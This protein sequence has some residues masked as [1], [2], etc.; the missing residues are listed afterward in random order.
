MKS[1]RRIFGLVLLFLGLA[2]L[3][4]MGWSI[5]S[6]PDPWRRGFAEVSGMA[7]LAGA[8]L[9]AGLWIALNARRLQP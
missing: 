4:W 7:A 6:V 8:G 9:V 5:F 2:V 3:A 1:P